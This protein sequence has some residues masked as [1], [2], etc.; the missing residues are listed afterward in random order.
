MLILVYI[1]L[2]VALASLV[3]AL[4]VIRRAFRSINSLKEEV[5]AERTKS[6]QRGWNDAIN[7]VIHAPESQITYLRTTE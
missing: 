5:Y 3:T 6:W 7:W 4:L 1:V 2:A